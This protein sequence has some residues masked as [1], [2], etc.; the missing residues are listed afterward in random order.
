MGFLKSKKGS[1][2]SDYFKLL[3]DVG[4]FKNGATVDV[5]L[6]DD[7]LEITPMSKKGTSKVS[8]AYSK[9]TDVFHGRSGELIQKQK[10]VIGRA[11]AGGLLFGG[12]GAV[13]GAV[14]GTGTKE[15]QDPTLYLIISYTDSDGN[16]QYLQ[17][18]DTRNYHGRKLAKTLRELADISS[19]PQS[20]EIEL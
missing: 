2:I 13:V 9:I 15:A 1:V 17:F 14:S 12:I 4:T 6:Y 10:S 11:V 19:S 3:H 18:E 5:A 7:H 16:E 20:E 8:L